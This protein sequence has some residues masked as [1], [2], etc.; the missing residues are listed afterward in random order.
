MT[1]ELGLVF[2]PAAAG[3]PGAEAGHLERLAEGAPGVD[4]RWCRTKD[5][6]ASLLPEAAVALV[7]TFPEFLNERAGKLKILSTPSAGREL[8]RARPR[9]GLEIVFASFHGELMA[10]TVLGMMLA[11]ARGIAQSAEP[12]R[13]GEWPRREVA[14]A[15][16]PLRGSHAVVLGFGHIGKWIA[17]TLK[18][19]GVRVTGVNRSNLERPSFFGPR[20]RVVPVS[21]LDDELPEADH[22]VVA[23]P[24]DT[25]T[26]NLIDAGRLALLP[27]GAY[28]YNLGRGNAV[29]LDALREALV[30]GRLAGAGLDVF[31][32]EPLPADAAI[33]SCPRLVMTPHVSAFGPN[34]LDLYVDELLPRLKNL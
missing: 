27:A 7:W 12:M 19:L 33:R 20:D 32:E 30:A 25:G 22:L 16:R 11:F 6:F 8:V 23:V 21:R 14:E 24:S 2:L 13:A 28:V 10:E 17:R 18:P 31:P 9:P 34:Y 5:E 29:D 15:V 26:D 4:W 1:K 3:L